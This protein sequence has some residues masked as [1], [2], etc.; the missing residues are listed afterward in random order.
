MEFAH[1]SYP[2]LAIVGGFVV[3]TY[4][5]YRLCDQEGYRE[6]VGEIPLPE[7]AGTRATPG[8]QVLPVEWFYDAD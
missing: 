7:Q 5:Y 8:L 6:L 1:S 4:C 2:R 3:L